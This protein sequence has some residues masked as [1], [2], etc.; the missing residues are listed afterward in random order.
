MAADNP[1]FLI[2]Q[3]EVEEIQKRLESLEKELPGFSRHHIREVTSILHEVRE[4]WA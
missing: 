3:D 1:W 4:R 2:T